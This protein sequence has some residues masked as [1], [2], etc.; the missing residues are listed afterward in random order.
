MF[1]FEKKNQKT[2]AYSITRRANG[3]GSPQT[4]SYSAASRSGRRTGATHFT[5]FTLWQRN[6][7]A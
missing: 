5:L 6:G 7:D 2:F 3:V 4:R 1:F